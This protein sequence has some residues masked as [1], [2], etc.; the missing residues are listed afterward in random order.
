MDPIT[1]ALGIAKLTGLDKTIGGWFGGDNGEKVA[2]KVLDIAQTYTGS[3]NPQEALAMIENSSKWQ[4][5]IKMALLN[6][7]QELKTLAFMNT[8]DA[9]LMQMKALEQDDQFSKHFV[10][11]LAIFWSIF[12]VVYIACITFLTIPEES[13]RF[14]DTILGFLLGTVIATM[15][16]YFWG[17]NN[18]NEK[19]TDQQSL[20]D[21]IG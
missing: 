16:N 10:Y 14:A 19:R 4:H 12:A 15:L 17:S 2:A 8:K 1:I 7:E 21:L 18:S 3:S 11:Y 9:R 6:N 5:D 20:K 13:V